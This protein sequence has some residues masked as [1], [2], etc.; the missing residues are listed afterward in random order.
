MSIQSFL[1]ARPS[2]SARVS[3]VRQALVALVGLIAATT[4]HAQASLINDRGGGFGFG[5]RVMDRN[6]DGSSAAQ[7]LSTAFPQGMCYFGTTQTEA[8]INNNGNITFGGSFGGFSPVPFPVADQAMSAAVWADEDTRGGS[9]TADGDGGNAVY[10]SQTS[11]DFLVTYFKVGRF[12]AN[13]T[14]RNSFQLRIANIIDARNY[15][16]EFRYN[17]IG[18]TTASGSG[19]GPTEAQVGFDAGNGTD[20]VNVAQSRTA[21]VANMATLSN[22]DQDGIFRFPIRNCSVPRCGDSIIDSNERCDD[23]NTAA[24]D[25]CDANCQ[26]EGTFVDSDGD[27]L[28]DAEEALRGTNP[29]DT[30]TDDDGIL[31]GNEIRGS[32]GTDP[33]DPDTDS[34]GV[35]DGV[36]YDLGT[37]PT[38]SDSD[39]DGLSDRDESKAGTNPLAPDTDSDGLDDLAELIAGTNPTNPDTDNDGVIDGEDPSP[40]GP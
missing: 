6:D 40:R 23:G 3:R 4:A 2:G 17:A 25:G 26:L 7:S 31:D 33:L 32:T 16:I 10:L 19:F 38:N 13:A 8:F 28:S 15:D 29:N 30:D 22:V 39:G 18:W 12:S 37:S 34:D 27:G 20:F 14:L 9:G 5:T 24:N 36:E 1:L 35:D 21:A 11:N